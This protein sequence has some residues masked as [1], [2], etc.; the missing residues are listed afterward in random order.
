MFLHRSDNERI[1]SLIKILS[2]K[3]NIFIEYSLNVTLP[4]VYDNELWW[5]DFVI[6][7]GFYIESKPCMVFGWMKIRV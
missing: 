2:K 5:T 3:N 7:Y 6:V 4:F 1:F